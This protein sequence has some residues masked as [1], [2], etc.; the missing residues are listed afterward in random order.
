MM[1]SKIPPQMWFQFQTGSIKRHD[2][3]TSTPT[4]DLRFQFQTGSIK[5]S[6][7]KINVFV[8][9]LFQFQTGSIK[10]VIP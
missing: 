3:K 9:G 5:R 8:L 2:E 1:G 7:A 10:S 4:L 6:I